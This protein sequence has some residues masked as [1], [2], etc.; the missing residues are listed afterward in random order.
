MRHATAAA[1]WRTVAAEAVRVARAQWVSSLLIAVLAGVTA[2]AVLVTTGHAEASRRSVLATVDDVGSALLVVSDSGTEPALDGRFVAAVAGLDGVGWTFGLGPVVDVSNADL[3]DGSAGVPMRALVGALPVDVVVEEG[4][5][6]EAGE[7]VVGAAARDALRLRDASGGVAWADRR[8]PVVGAFAATGPL[9]RLG[10][11]ALVVPEDPADTR[12]LHVYV[13][14][15][16]PAVVDAVADQL[17]RMLPDRGVAAGAVTVETSDGVIALRA[18][19]G[20]RLDR[21]GVVLLCVTLGLGLAL[22]VVVTG[23]VT[24]ARRPDLGR[25]RALGATRSAIVA[26]VVLHTM[27]SAL[28][29]AVAGVVAG[30]LLVA[31]LVGQPPGAAFLAAL[32]VVTVLCVTGGSSLPAWVA[33]RSDPVPILRVP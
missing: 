4:R 27:L 32:L 9:A 5:V 29:G 2:L 24:F 12:V 31:R 18:A 21:D 14:A 23:I 19:L 25:R 6:P 10:D 13:R 7:V 33:A 11:L 30:A 26:L 17:R 3:P 1:P 8:A 15:A 28:L 22:A 20:Q 16:S